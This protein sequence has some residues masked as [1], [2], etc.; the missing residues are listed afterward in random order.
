MQLTCPWCGPRDEP[1]FVCGG[2][3]QLTRPPLECSDAA[4]G[5]Y[6]FFRDN[7]K[8]V[9]HERWRHTSGCGRWF[10]IVRNTVTHELLGVY[11]IGEPAP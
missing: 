10:N 5:D 6:L 11:R 4:W 2:P 9:F 3:A 7:P 1:E 8:G